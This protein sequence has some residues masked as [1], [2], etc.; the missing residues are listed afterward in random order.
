MPLN[1]YVAALRVEK[2]MEL[3]DAEAP[4]GWYG[5]I[6]THA[7]KLSDCSMCVLGQLWESFDNGVKALDLT[8]EDGEASYDEVVTYGFDIAD[9]DYDNSSAIGGNT[10]TA[11]YDVLTKAWLDAILA[12]QNA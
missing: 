12:R 7:L 4:E 3:L 9:S 1:P 2:G 5:Q 6:D 10:A 8:N 11:G